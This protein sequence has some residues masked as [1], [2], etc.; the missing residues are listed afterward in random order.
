MRRY[1]IFLVMLVAFS[2]ASFAQTTAGIYAEGNW[3]SQVS[4]SDINGQPFVNKFPDV[5]GSPYLHGFKS[6]NILLYGGKG[7]AHVPS[8]INFYDQ[9][10]S[11]IS[12][13][14]QEVVTNP[15]YIREVNFTD[16]TLVGEVKHVFRTSFPPT[17]N[18]TGTQFY[19]VL[20]DGHCT[21]LKAIV[22]SISETR[23]ALTGTV[24]RDFETLETLY[25]FQDGKMTRV[26]KDK[27]FVLS[28]L[29]DKKEAI[30][31][32]VQ[33]HKTNAK[34]PLQLTELVKYYNSQF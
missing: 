14:G 21:L 15:G 28:Q 27:D 29:S 23:N 32:Y 26:R 30:A 1:I 18:L 6:S 34:D 13:N 25:F 19:E 5:S 3:G 24:E 4:V 33:S 17:D 11:F 10:V 8:R 22:K 7:F 9:S 20:A 12:A 16:T 31:Q 2:A